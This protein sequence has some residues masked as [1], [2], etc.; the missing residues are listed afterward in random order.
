VGV[1]REVGE[2]IDNARVVDWEGWRRIDAAER[3]R[4]G[5]VGKEREKFTRTAE[6][7][8]VLG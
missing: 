3:E 4:G 8:A 2:G 6:M 5:K 1:R 7:L